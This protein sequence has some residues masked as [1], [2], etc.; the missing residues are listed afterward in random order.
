[1]KLKIARKLVFKKWQEALGGEIK[2]VGCGGAA[3]QPRLEQIFW[4][5]QIPIQQGYGLTETSPLIAINDKNSPD[6]MI[7]S[8]GCIVENVSVKIAHD[9]EILCK[10]PNVMKGYYKND[11]LTQEVIDSEGWF[12]TGDIGEIVDGKFLTITD[13][14]KEIFKISNGKYIA[15]QLIEN[16][17]KQSQ[18]IEQLMVVGENQ[19]FPSALIS[20]NFSIL[21]IWCNTNQIGYS[22]RCEIIR[23]PKVIDLFHNEIKRLNKHLGQVEEVKKF[24]LICDD[25][26]PTSGELSP[27]L[28]LKRKVIHQKYLHLVNDIYAIKN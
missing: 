5:A 27:T 26:S 14:K 11:E 16:L 2:F 21:Q 8:V 1:M 25:W 15:P 4:A 12:H 24:R 20:P 28:K 9:G 3:L 23:H 13:R 19:K 18:F 6:R 10:G 7:G 17:F 22:E